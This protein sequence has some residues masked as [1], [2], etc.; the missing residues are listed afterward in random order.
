MCSVAAG[1]KESEDD[2]GSLT[3]CLQ[4]MGKESKVRYIFLTIRTCTHCDNLSKVSLR[5]FI[6]IFTVSFVSKEGNLAK[7]HSQSKRGARMSPFI[8]VSV[9]I[10]LI[11]SLPNSCTFLYKCSSVSMVLL[12]GLQAA[13]VL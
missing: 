8:L 4:N 3:V 9:K 5:Y 2:N 7:L 10:V 11:S 13:S 12:L 6:L 1:L